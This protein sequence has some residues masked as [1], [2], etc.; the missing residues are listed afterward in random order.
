MKIH[1]TDANFS[2]EFA[3][4]Q[5]SL[6]S[7]AQLKSDFIEIGGVRYFVGKELG[8]G[9]TI[10]VD[11]ERGKYTFDNVKL[12]VEGNT[13][14]VDGNILM[15]K[16]FSDYDLV[17]SGKDAELAS[18]FKLL[19][20]Q[21]QK[22]ISDFTTKGR[23]A[24][25]STIK[26][27]YSASES[28][29]I[30]VDLSLEDGNITSERLDDPLKD[31]SFSASFTNGKGRSQRNSVFTINDFKGYFSRE[32]IESK[33]QIA[34]FEDPSIDFQIDGVIPMESVYG[35]FNNEAITDGDGEIE[36][37]K[38]KLKGRYKDMI[39]PSRIHRVKTSGMVE[40]DNAELI[41][42]KEKMI[43]DK[44]NM[45]LENN[46]LIVETEIS[47]TSFLFYLLT[48][49]TQKRQSFDLEPLWIQ[50]IWIWIVWYGC[51]LLHLSPL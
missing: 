9:A 33:L 39:T 28:P 16:N 4:D 36:I 22:Y 37:S 8:Y 5:F 45:I 40:F 6:D 10:D 43:L 26:G 47:K 15:K 44:G 20:E 29:A 41:I 31:V 14:H 51:L 17:V 48:S 11:L 3:N 50:R 49:E 18:I 12:M 30:K 35:L 34:N 2:G 46:E 1:L 23:F 38:F 27:R 7:D 32:L 21:Y 42:N 13:L 25:N 19:P 24:L